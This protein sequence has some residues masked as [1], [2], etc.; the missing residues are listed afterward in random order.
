MSTP[1]GDGKVGAGE[2]EETEQPN[3]M[4]DPLLDPAK[5]KRHSFYYWDNRRKL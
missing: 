5:R 2:V 3:T 1:H 4:C